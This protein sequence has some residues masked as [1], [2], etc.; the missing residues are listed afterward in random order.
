MKSV[1]HKTQYQY[2][3][4]GW[5]YKDWEGTVYPLQREAFFN[6][7]LFL[8]NDFDF[9]EVNTTFYRIPSLKLTSGWVKKTES[10]P[11]FSFWI[12]IYQNF[13]HKR[14]LTGDELR[15][16]FNSCQPLIRSKKLA[17]FLAQFPYS[18]KLNTENMDYLEELQ[19]GFNGYPFAV[20]F[21]HDS[22]NREEII[23]FFKQNRLI[24]VNIDQP[25]ISRSLPLTS[26]FTHP[27]VSY[28]RLHG[29]NYQS[30]FSNQGRDARYN[31]SYSTREL[32][33][34]AEKIKKLSNLA[35]TIF[36]SGNNHYKG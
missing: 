28:F 15:D 9:V 32:N 5:S 7:L 4:A 6:P 8:S 17:G 23:D 19:S 26:E 16:F 22:W 31:Y 1:N 14:Q 30:W 21:R 3:T 13:T 34:I 10:I 25:V 33:Q 27:L 35:K 29:R 2:G 24:W 20:E 11:G 12:K 36:I 18:F